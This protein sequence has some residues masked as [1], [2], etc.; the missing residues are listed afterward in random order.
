M[1][2]RSP[3][4][5]SLGDAIEMLCCPSCKQ[6]DIHF[7]ENFLQKKGF[8]SVFILK[9]KHCDF[10]KELNSSK[11][12][13]RSYKINRRIQG[14]SSIEKFAT[15]MNLPRPMTHKNYYNSLKV[16]EKA[17][18]EVTEES[19]Q[20]AANEIKNGSADVVDTEISGDS[21]WQRRGFSSLNGL[22]RQYL[23]RQERFW[24]TLK[25]MSRYCKACKLKEPLKNSDPDAHAQWLK[26]HDCHK[27][28]QLGQ[29]KA[30]FQ[31]QLQGEC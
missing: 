19:M 9:C 17:V 5:E 25:Y 28:L 24:W 30:S 8:S 27:T 6:N 1:I 2:R 3:D 18:R 22:L 31:C 4:T 15:H 13:G 12:C 16:I 20:D 14:Y 26:T 21:S 10:K 7:H 23:C 29:Q 11:Q